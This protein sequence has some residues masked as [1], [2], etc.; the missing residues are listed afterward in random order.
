[1]QH[2]LVVLLLLLLLLLL[3]TAPTIIFAHRLT[4]KG[5]RVVHEEGGAALGQRRGGVGLPEDM[6]SV[7]VVWFQLLLY[8]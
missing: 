5:W 2:E 8:T 1:M 6:I 7:H 3:C 4:K